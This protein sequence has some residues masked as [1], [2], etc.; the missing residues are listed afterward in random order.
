MP[1][2]SKD[3]AAQVFINQW[4]DDKMAEREWLLYRLAQIEPVLIRYERLKA[5]S[6]ERG[7]SGYST[8]GR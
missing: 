5:R 8:T 1:P 6:K 7:D 2:N 4:L 3:R